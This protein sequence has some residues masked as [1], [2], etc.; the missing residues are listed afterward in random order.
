MKTRTAAFISLLALMLA[1]QVQAQ[2]G[3]TQGRVIE[4]KP[5][6][7]EV[8]VPTE[9]EVC[10]DK[11]ISRHHHRSRTPSLL[12]GL[13]GGVVGH[14]FGDGRGQDAMTVA[15][16]LIG[17][18]VG[19]DIEKERRHHRHGSRTVQHCRIEQAYYRDERQVGYEVSYE[20]QGQVYHTQT[21][22]DPGD[23]I[24]LRVS[25]EPVRY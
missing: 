21:D 17:A 23:Y 3:I 2:S 25:V 5:I 24:D 11:R 18:S 8:R 13:I 12:G 9:K 16:A 7:K 4:S 14:Q 6:Y 22:E 20:Y 19:H 15:G 1:G 10:W